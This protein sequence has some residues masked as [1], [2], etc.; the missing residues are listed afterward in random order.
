MTERR[1]VVVG[2]EFRV[3]KDEGKAPR[4]EGYA[5]VF[6]SPSVDLGGFREIV[7]PGAFTKTLEEGDPRAYW[8]HDSSRILGRRSAGTLALEEDEHGLRISL[9]PGDTSWGIDALKSIERGDVDQMSFGFRTIKDR[10]YTD[11]QTGTEVREL[12]EVDLLEVSPVSMPAYEQTEVQVRSLLHDLTEQ[13]SVQSISV[14]ESLTA[15]LEGLVKRADPEED[16]RGTRGSRL[17]HLRRRQQ[18]IEV[19][20]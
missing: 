18:L 19:G 7:K 14:S 9:D 6:D 17:A 11:E 8:Q 20:L 13:G 2:A 15:K 5:S 16:E 3:A 1:V 10:F 4:I 12:L